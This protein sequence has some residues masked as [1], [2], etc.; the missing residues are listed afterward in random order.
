MGTAIRI[1]VGDKLWP[2]QYS[3]RKVFLIVSSNRPIN[4]GRHGGD[5]FHYLRD[6]LEPRAMPNFDLLKARADA[7]TIT[8][9]NGLAI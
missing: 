1:F 7:S 3:R 4:S 8:V 5:V 6:H 9:A 2:N